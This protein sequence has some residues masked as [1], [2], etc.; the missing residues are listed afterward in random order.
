M[1]IGRVAKTIGDHA[2]RRLFA[3]RGNHSEVHLNETELAL[4]FSVCAQAAW[5]SCM[6]AVQKVRQQTDREI[7]DEA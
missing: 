6:A 5:E 3:A 2:A 4:A 7:E 1:A